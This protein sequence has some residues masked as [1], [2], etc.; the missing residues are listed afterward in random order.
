MYIFRRNDPP[1]CVITQDT[2]TLEEIGNSR[3]H[4]VAVVL[5]EGSMSTFLGKQVHFQG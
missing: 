2:M 3:F 5:K 4:F 1:L